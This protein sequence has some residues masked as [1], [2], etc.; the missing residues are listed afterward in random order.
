M[1]YLFASVRASVKYNQGSEI[2]PC[3]SM[4]QVVY[5]Q[6]SY[7]HHAPIE[8]ERQ[9]TQRCAIRDNSLTIYQKLSDWMRRRQNSDVNSTPEFHSRPFSLPATI[10]FT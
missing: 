1:W 7:N 8:F 10:G 3:L 9:Y 2:K 5:F 6:D 4:T